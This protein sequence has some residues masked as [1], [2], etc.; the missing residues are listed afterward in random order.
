MG[1]SRPARRGGRAGG[2]EWGCATETLPT[3][4][5]RPPGGNIRPGAGGRFFPFSWAF[6][7]A[8][9][10]RAPR[11]ELRI[12]PY[13]PTRVTRGAGG[14]S[15]PP[16]AGPMSETNGATAAGRRVLV[17]DGNADAAE[18]LAVL[19]RLHGHDAVTAH[20]GPDAL[21]AARSRPPDVAFLS[22][23][24]PGM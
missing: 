22:I 20:S 2:G 24:L 10:R 17:V 1:R 14:R 7:R 16:E 23:L 12:L 4:T 6:R 3:C 19:L 21:A 11:C 9:D 18:S 8:V 15:A 13:L 5:N